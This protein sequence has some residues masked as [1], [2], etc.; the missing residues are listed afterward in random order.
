MD[1]D[2]DDDANKEGE[3]VK[4]KPA[5]QTGRAYIA[6]HTKRRSVF[7][8]YKK[9][10]NN[11]LNYVSQACGAYGLLYLRPYDLIKSFL[12]MEQGREYTRHQIR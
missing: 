11:Q 4:A 9:R 10:M 5:S 3:Q 2:V 12:L 1:D 6:D 7:R 8:T